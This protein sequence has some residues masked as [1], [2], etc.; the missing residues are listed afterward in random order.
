M[1]TL[2]KAKV[3]MVPAD[4]LSEATDYS[5]SLLDGVRTFLPQAITFQLVSATVGDPNNGGKGVIGEPAYLEELIPSLPSI[6]AGEYAYG[7]TFKWDASQGISGAVIVKN[8]RQDKFLLKSLII[9]DFPGKGHVHFDC[10]SWVYSV[11]KYSYDRIFFAN[12]TYLPENTPEPLKPYRQEELLH[13]RGDDVNRQMEEW[14]RIYNYACYN[15]LGNP[16]KKASL[17]RPVLG[18]SEEYPYPRRG[19]TGRP[20]ANSDPNSESRLGNED[21]YVPRDERF[22]HLKQSDFRDNLIKALVKS[23]I[24][25]LNAIINGTPNEFDSFEDILRMFEGGL[26]VPDVPLVDEVREGIKSEL[27]KSIVGPDQGGKRLI[28][29]SKPHVIQA[30]PHAWDTD[31]EFARE[32][33]AGVNPVIISRLQE[34]PPSSKLDPTE[35]GNQNSSITAAHIEHN[36]EGL[37]V[38]QALSFSKLFI[39]D[40]HDAIMPYV[41]RI[42]SNTNNRIYATRTLLFLKDDGALKPLAI[43]LSLPHPDGEKCG[44][45]SKVFTPSQAGVEASIWR[46][47]KAYVAVNDSGVHQLISH[48]LLTHASIEPFVIATNRHLS[49]MHPINKL[50]VPHYRDTMNINALA[51]KS[52]ISADGIIEKTFFPVNYS[53]EIS[54]V[55]Y[56]SWNFVEQALPAD[57]LKRGIVVED[58]TQPNNLRL[59]ISDYPYAVDGL[60]IWSAIETWVTNYISIYYPTD[61][62]VQS[63]VELQSWW[64]EIQ[65]VGHGDHKNAPW[66]PKMQTQTDLIQSCTT[67]IW[68]SSALHAAVNFGQYPFAGYVPNRPTLSRKFMPEPG[69]VDYERLKTNPDKVFL[70]T[71]T[72]ELQSIIEIALIEILSTH[73]SDEIYLGQRDSVEWTEDQKALEAFKRFGEK[74]SE[75]EGEIVK[76]NE[77]P[78]YVN[79]RGPVDMPYSL[80]VPSSEA[81]LT[82]K[83]IPN[84]ISI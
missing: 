30:D 21:F 64:A 5:A 81:G 13:L 56:K 42:N 39:L 80:L 67:I 18:G 74:L 40:H 10:N 48:W 46:L 8:N 37:T 4:A 61:S 41:N 50:L 34:F 69:S 2:V 65:Q 49:A 73:A 32:M 31:E 43:E 60:K 51:R 79:R 62:T 1:A 71:I 11:D 22:G 66:W 72:R 16:D 52:L 57:L 76:M 20:P 12:D 82:A 25:L 59:L 15:D 23:L 77:D 47:A 24:P 36:L 68:V 26:P 58:S 7:V 44:A 19:R 78:R 27:L 3:V 38:E 83:G 33:L 28:K 84:S 17:A 75:I 63:D 45:V 6:T 53:M 70:E 35:Y 29:F 14:D 9:E 55:I 54:S